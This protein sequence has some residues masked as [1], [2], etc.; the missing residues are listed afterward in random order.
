MCVGGST[1]SS[2]HQVSHS[3]HFIVLHNYWLIPLILLIYSIHH[4]LP[5][6]L[7]IKYSNRFGIWPLNGDII[8]SFLCTYIMILYHRCNSKP[9]YFKDKDTFLG[10]YNL[11]Y[12]PANSL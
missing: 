3:P 6:H 8:E 5:S 12:I 1:S 4:S 10:K 11:L 9:Q 2:E 7:I